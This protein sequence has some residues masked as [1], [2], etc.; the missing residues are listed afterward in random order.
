[1]QLVMKGNSQKLFTKIVMFGDDSLL[2]YLFKYDMT[3]FKIVA[4]CCTMFNFRNSPVVS[5]ALSKHMIL[6]CDLSRIILCFFMQ[7]LAKIVQSTS[8]L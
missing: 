3:I 1:M 5:R 6:L 8:D 2:Y 4:L 7:H